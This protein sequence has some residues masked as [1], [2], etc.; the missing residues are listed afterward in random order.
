M[1][2]LVSVIVPVYRVEKYLEKCINSIIDQT[3][4]N[5]EIILIDDG[6][7][8]KCPDICDK[9]KK[10]DKR[11]NV[12]HKLNGGVSSARNIGLENA[13]GEYIIFVD[14]DDYVEKNMIEVLYKNMIETNADISIGNF[15]YIYDDK[16]VDNYFPKYSNIVC[17][18]SKYEYLY[19]EYYNIVSII[20]W[21]KMY[22]KSIFKN[23]K[24]P[25]GMVEEDEAVIFDLFKKAKKISFIDEKIYNYVQREDS[26]MHN[27]SLKRLDAIKI[28]E[29][30]INKILKENLGDNLLK[31]EYFTYMYLF[32]NDIIPGLIKINQKEKVKVYIKKCRKLALE[33]KSKF[34]LSLKEK[35]K[36]LII[37]ISPMLFS[38]I[39][40]RNK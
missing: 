23:I 8:D 27:F 37:L 13:R 38:K 1:E 32:E 28:R 34:S 18:D 22:K 21:G 7:D 19:D 39:V 29:D 14:S 2:G 5:I 20:P 4:K 11:I 12:I 33:I 30:R 6:S 36:I 35:I 9:Y 25:L 31:K 26:I 10:N 3:Y 17:D 15:R 40:I 24:Y 16:I